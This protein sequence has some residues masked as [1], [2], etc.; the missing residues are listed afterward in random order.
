MEDN[1]QKILSPIIDISGETID[2][3]MIERVGRAG[4]DQAWLRYSVYF[5]SGREVEIYHERMTEDRPQMKRE[6]FVELWKA[7]NNQ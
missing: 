1:K 2:L 5:T 3:R 6:K 7:Y 4:G